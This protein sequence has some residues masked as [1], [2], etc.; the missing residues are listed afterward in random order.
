MRKIRVAALIDTMNDQCSWYRAL[1]PLNSMRRDYHDKIEIEFANKIN[2]QDWH[3]LTDKDVLY[4]LR[5]W[6]KDQMAAIILARSLGVKVWVDYDDDFT[7]DQECSWFKDVGASYNEFARSSVKMAHAI[8]F[9]TPSIFNSYANIDPG[10]K[11][12]STLIRNGFDFHSFREEKPKEKRNRTI[13]WRG[14]ETHDSD[15]AEVAREYIDS[16]NSKNIST[17]FYWGNPKHVS[18]H[19]K[20]KH[21]RYSIPQFHK[22]LFEDA[23]KII[24]APLLNTKFNRGKSNAAWIEGTASG[25]IIVGRDLPEWQTPNC[26]R[27]KSPKDF[28]EA[29]FT[30]IDMT[31]HDAKIMA[32][33]GLEYLHEH[34]DLQKINKKRLDLLNNLVNTA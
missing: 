1:G 16:V 6:R 5:P 32:N 29:I 22:Y 8:T 23:H 33:Q 7:A 28:K 30:A 14:S 24:V 11:N 27:Y 21:F 4:V 15:W 19:V 10:I 3:Y 12:N 26:I 31:D 20:S 17:Y 34:Y 13:G 2:P 9:S 18:Y 25:S